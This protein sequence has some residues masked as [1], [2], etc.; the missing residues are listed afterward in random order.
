MTVETDLLASVV[1][2]V[3]QSLAYGKL[4]MIAERFFLAQSPP[5]YRRIYRPYADFYGDP[6]ASVPCIQFE[7][8]FSP[9]PDSKR[10]WNTRHGVIMLSVIWIMFALSTMHWS[11]NLAFLIAKVKSN[12]VVNGA[13]RPLSDLMNAIVTINASIP[14]TAPLLVA[15]AR[16]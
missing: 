13:I 2:V 10:G 16:V 1:E 15:D 6:C 7:T 12:T 8:T 4:S 5:N 11:V 14:L 9:V 3:T